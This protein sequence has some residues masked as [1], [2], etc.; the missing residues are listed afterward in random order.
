MNPFELPHQKRKIEQASIPEDDLT[1]LIFTVINPNDHQ[2]S[3]TESLLEVSNKKKRNSTYVEKSSRQKYR[4]KAEM[5]ASIFKLLNK[6]EVNSSAS[7][8]FLHELIS[9]LSKNKREEELDLCNEIKTQYESLNQPG[10]RTM[11]KSLTHINGEINEAIVR[12]LPFLK[13]RSLKLHNQPAR[14]T[15][16]DK[17]NLS[18]ISDFM[19]DH[20]RYFLHYFL[21]NFC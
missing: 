9:E 3:F 2:N 8:E 13:A 1:S 11:I 20:C 4:I 17:I 5:K 14:K 19:H 12:H 18:F 10:K 6:H 7:L 16:S 21:L 15:R